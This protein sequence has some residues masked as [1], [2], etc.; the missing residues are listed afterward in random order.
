MTPDRGTEPEA[1]EGTRAG[2]VALVGRPNVGKSTLMNALIGERLSIVTPRAQ[3]T[4]ERV[5]GIYTDE[6]AQ[7]VFVDTPG[8]LE[9]KYLLQRAMLAE[10][11]TAVR[12]A[13]L[14]LLL[15]DAT[16]PDELPPADALLELEARRPSLFVVVNKVDAGNA[17]GVARLT[18]W[19]SVTLGI[20]ARSISAATGAGVEELRQLLVSALPRSPFLYPPDD[21]A[22][23]PVRFFVAEL[24]RETIFEQYEEEIPYS[25]VV[26]IEEYR[27]ADT[28]IYIRA[29]IYL[30]RASQKG[31]LLGKGGAAIRQLG[32]AAR[33][34]IEA[35]VGGHVF[36]DLWVKVLPGWR[37]KR[38]TLEY[39]GYPVPTEEG[40]QRR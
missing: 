4:R 17:G 30:E 16:R 25:T 11:L 13:D 12:E 37:K 1:G 34:K 22:A 7:L 3:T 14:V 8:L 21:I 20:A 27:E 5:L 40:P 6:R 35:F 33:A 32:A 31:I 19:G 26:R 23:Q 28:P 38:S 2:D 10:A 24:I 15:L 18:E 39:L 36:L 9:P 29:T